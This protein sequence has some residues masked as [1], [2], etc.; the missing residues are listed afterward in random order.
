MAKQ[1]FDPSAEVRTL[2]RDWR[3]LYRTWWS[4]HYTVGLLGVA[5]GVLAAGTPGTLGLPDWAPGTA[6]AVATSLVTF[7]GPLHKAQAYHRAFH[8][9]EQAGHWTYHDRHEEV[10]H[11]MQSFLQAPSG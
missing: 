2:S 6:A 5:A 8:E 3:R 1:E 9:V 4:V 10:L 11:I 7:L